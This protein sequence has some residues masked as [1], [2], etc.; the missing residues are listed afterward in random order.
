MSYSWFRVMT[1]SAGLSEPRQG[2]KS[3]TEPRCGI[4]SFLEL[5]SELLAE[6]DICK[7]NSTGH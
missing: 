7:K 3:S 4:C 6:A 5:V 1:T 2:T